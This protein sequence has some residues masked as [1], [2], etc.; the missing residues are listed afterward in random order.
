MLPYV[1]NML[2]VCQCMLLF[3]FEASTI[4][5]GTSVNRYL[6]YLNSLRIRI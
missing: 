1:Y 2:E 4:S 5:R 6:K 3:M